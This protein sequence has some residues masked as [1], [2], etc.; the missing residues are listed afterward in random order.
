MKV[1]MLTGDKGLTA[2]QIG[3]SCG[4]IPANAKKDTEGQPA[5]LFEVEDTRNVD[6]LKKSL[7]DCFEFFGKVELP[8]LKIS[9]S[10]MARALETTDL[11]EL[12]IKI[13]TMAHSV[14]LYRSSPAQKA[15]MVNLIK[16]NDKGMKTL[17]IG[18]GAN[19]VNMII[20]AHI[21]V[22]ILSKEGN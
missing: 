21:G 2:E 22:G 18:D 3:I 20:Q 1:W 15:D 8:K 9:G 5:T 13:A 4:I 17:A 11:R 7:H 16:N 6:L 14:I 19:D 12:V 10:T